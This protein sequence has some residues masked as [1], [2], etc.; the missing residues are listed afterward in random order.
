LYFPTLWYILPR[1]QIGQSH[2]SFLFQV[3]NVI[4]PGWPDEIVKKVAQNLAQYIFV[5]IDTRDLY[6]GKKLPKYL[7]LFC[8][9]AKLPKGRK[10]V[11]S[12]HPALGP[13]ET[14]QN[15]F[16]KWLWRTSECTKE[17]Q[18]IKTFLTLSKKNFVPSVLS[19]E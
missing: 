3:I 8:N 2:L 13:D 10:F 19:I 5:K 17:F 9:V 16:R 4:G 12:G 14:F 15:C 11:Q 7:G 1:N 6:Y 18:I